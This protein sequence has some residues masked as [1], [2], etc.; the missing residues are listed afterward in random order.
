MVLDFGQN[1][2]D[3][4]IPRPPSPNSTSHSDRTRN[5]IAQANLRF[6]RESLCLTM[7]E[8]SSSDDE[9]APADVV[10]GDPPVEAVPDLP[11][12]APVDDGAAPDS[13]D[14]APNPVDSDAV[15]SRRSVVTRTVLGGVCIFEAMIDFSLVQ[16]PRPDFNWYKVTSPAELKSG[17]DGVLLLG[18]HSVDAPVFQ[19]QDKAL[20][21]NVGLQVWPS[22]NVATT[23]TATTA[24]DDADPPSIPS[25]ESISPEEFLQFQQ[26]DSTRADK[27][28][29]VAANIELDK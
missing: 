26:Y 17:P 22:R 29:L 2:P 19:Y 25:L 27:E 28:A 11:D 13:P 5:N 15:P 20:T 7:T 12:A 4:V 6:G 3:L 24:D 16:V 1:N 23:Q 10:V 21:R 9:V 18:Y 14:D 8:S